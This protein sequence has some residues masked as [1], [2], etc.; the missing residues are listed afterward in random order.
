MRFTLYPH[1]RFIAALTITCLFVFLTSQFVGTAQELTTTEEPSVVEPSATLPVESPTDTPQ[2][3]DVET[4]TLVDASE[5]PSA[6]DAAPTATEQ[7]PTPS[8]TAT[9]TDEIPLPT[10]ETV[11][12]TLSTLPPE[13][14]LM[15][16]LND[17][18]D[19]GDLSAWR[20]GQG[21]SLVGVEGGQALQ[22]AGITA[23]AQYVQGDLMD[24]AVQARFLSSGGTAQLILRQSAGGSYSASLSPDGR[25]ELARSGTVMQT[26]AVTLS[27]GQWHSVRF[28]AIGSV[29]QVAVD[30]VEVLAL[31]DESPLPPGA[32]LVAGVFAPAQDGT[33]PFLQVDDVQIWVPEGAVVP[34]ATQVEVGVTPAATETI[35]TSEPTALI[36]ETEPPTPTLDPSSRVIVVPTIIMEVTEEATEEFAA[37]AVAAASYPAPSAPALSAPNSNVST[38]SSRPTL[39]WTGS[40]TTSGA[41]FRYQI[42]IDNNSNFESPVTNETLDEGVLSYFP[43]S[44]LADAKYYWRVRT[45]NTVDAA[46]SWSN[47]RNFTIDSAPP[48]SPSLR[49]PANGGSTTDT[50]PTFSWNSVSGASR[51]ELRYGTGTP[52]SRVVSDLRSTS[53]T[54]PSPLLIRTYF[55]QVRALDAAGNT[56]G[57]SEVRSVNVVSASNSAPRLNR[58]DSASVTLTWSAMSWATMFEVQIDENS[59]FGSPVYKNSSIGPG[60]LSVTTS[61]ADGTYYWRVRARKANGTSWSGWSST[62]VFTVEAG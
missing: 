24:A 8:A 4:S 21:W 17:S 38:S 46:G 35:L 54:A 48:L 3:A 56:S 5:T 32:V 6:T 29:L 2:A 19:G 16:L 7:Q 11:E 27:E 1:R 51:Y 39:S 44:A 28:S 33:A 49:S 14:P 26:A 25:V 58:S 42:Q 55:W 62:G 37:V 20:L 10:V 9:A 31:Q 57:W 53:Y 43:D 61:L 47:T 45:I 15:L 18:F 23:A 60:T 12:P 40:T 36:T 13:P 50:T 30:G 41:P 59:D 34:M 22:T 52:L